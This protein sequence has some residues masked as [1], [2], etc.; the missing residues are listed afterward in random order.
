MV[1]ETNFNEHICVHCGYLV[2]QCACTSESLAGKQ[3]QSQLSF[4]QKVIERLD[5]IIALL[6]EPLQ[7]RLLKV[8]E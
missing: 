7:E 4:Q 8:F 1:T 2:A 6:E 3:Y 5:K